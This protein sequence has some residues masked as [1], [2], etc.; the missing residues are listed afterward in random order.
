M[1]LDISTWDSETP[2]KSLQACATISCIF[3]K[4]RGSVPLPFLFIT[5][6]LSGDIKPPSSLLTV[7]VLI[8]LKMYYYL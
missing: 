4:L 5:L 1:P 7:D 3:S 6:M 8:I 2:V